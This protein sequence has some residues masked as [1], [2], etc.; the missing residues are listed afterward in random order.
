MRSLIFLSIFYVSIFGDNA[1]YIEI[2]INYLNSNDRVV[3]GAEDKDQAQPQKKDEL[4]EVLVSVLDSKGDL[5]TK[6]INGDALKTIKIDSKLGAKPVHGRLSSN[7]NLES[8]KNIGRYLLDYSNVTM[9]S[10]QEDIIT[11]E[12]GGKSISKTILLS[13]ADAKG[14]IVRAAPPSTFKTQNYINERFEKIRMDDEPIDYNLSQ[15]SSR[16]PGGVSGITIPI[17]IYASTNAPSFTKTENADKGKFTIAPNLEGKNIIVKV[18]ADYKISGTADV[19]LSTHTFS[20]TRGIAKGN[21]KIMH[22]LPEDI[23]GNNTFETSLAGGLQVAFIAYV[24][25]DIEIANKTN[26]D[27]E[28]MQN[29]FKIKG[30]NNSTDTVRVRSSDPSNI[31]VGKFN[32]QI[33]NI[34]DLWEDTSLSRYVVNAKG[35]STFVDNGKEDTN[36]SLEDNITVTLVDANGNP[37]FISNTVPSGAN[38][39]F[40]D[41]KSSEHFSYELN[42]STT[43]SGTEIVVSDDNISTYAIFVI[44]DGDKNI[45]KSQTL[46]I[47]FRQGILAGSDIKQ[48]SISHIPLIESIKSG[49][50]YIYSSITTTTTTDVALN[51]KESDTSTI[52]QKDLKI[53]LTSSSVTTKDNE[54]IQLRFYDPGR[55]DY[56]DTTSLNKKFKIDSNGSDK[57]GAATTINR[58]G[59]FEINVTG[60]P[61][62]TIQDAAGKVDYATL[63]F[64]DYDGVQSKSNSAT[65]QL[66]ANEGRKVAAYVDVGVLSDDRSDFYPGVKVE[67]KFSGDAVSSGDNVDIVFDT[68]SSKGRVGLESE[69]FSEDLKNSIKTIMPSSKKITLRLYDTNSSGVMYHIKRISVNGASVNYRTIENNSRDTD[70]I[71]EWGKDYNVTIVMSREEYA[72]TIEIQPTNAT[73]SGDGSDDRSLKAIPD[74]VTRKTKKKIITYDKELLTNTYYNL[75]SNQDVLVIQDAYG[76]KLEPRAYSDLRAYSLRGTGGIDFDNL[77]YDSWIKFKDSAAGTTQTLTVFFE[78]KPEISFDIRFTNIE[79]SDSQNT[80]FDMSMD[81]GSSSYTIQNSEFVVKIKPDG[82]KDQE[83]TKL[84]FTHSDSSANV[85]VVLSDVRSPAPGRAFDS[86]LDTNNETISTIDADGSYYIVSTDK[87]GILTI[88][89]DATIEARQSETHKEEKIHGSM[90]VTVVRVDAAKPTINPQTDISIVGN[91]I[92]VRVTDVNLNHVQTKI[93]LYTKDN[94][95]IQ[96]AVYSNGVFTFANLPIGTY[97]IDVK[98]IDFSNNDYS[99]TFVRNI[100][101]AGATTQFPTSGGNVPTTIS[102]NSV[103]LENAMISKTY[104]I[105][106]MFFPYDFPDKPSYLDF[107]Y[108]D[109]SNNKTYQF[110]G[111]TPNANNLFGFKEVQLSNVNVQDAYSFYMVQ[112]DGASGAPDAVGPLGWV[113]FRKTTLTKVSKLAGATNEG[114][115]SYQGLNLKGSLV[116]NR[117]VIFTRN[118]Y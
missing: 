62:I 6:D 84:K 110:Q 90:S 55:Y 82:N 118:R 81:I 67:F 92:I 75:F 105:K 86:I 72:H 61:V 112:L 64:K 5:A 57:P 52:S 50:S 37:A 68:G 54:I 95:F 99:A 106:G 74:L 76:N 4:L 27:L 116:G 58:Y 35:V 28:E 33:T 23:D 80:R 96:D 2:Q 88:T 53:R 42:S 104:P 65:I 31:K 49:H 44:A 89:A 43:K 45:S 60:D 93:R 66:L 26:L 48:L 51:R 14:L 63:T 114:T 11:I 13:S 41:E 8:E 69:P 30:D 19:V 24:Q 17:T 113:I 21:I 102:P 117:E 91:S 97:R 46:S 59:T 34:K 16:S 56:L 7:R 87:P 3:V 79:F 78:K 40:D 108:Y 85:R 36:G 32:N 83:N 9:S 71:Y 15:P 12:G 115:F 103:A 38:L 111:Q 70:D 1:N 47:D 18:M 39:L 107:A 77:D 109:Y 94:V 73:A 22:A 98:A 20:M 100:T 101:V 29:T 10:L 25:D